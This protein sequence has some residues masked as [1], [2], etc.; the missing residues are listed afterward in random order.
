MTTRDAIQG[1]FKALQ[2][3]NGWESFLADDIAF[4]SFTSPVKRVTGKAAY[5]QATKRFYSTIAAMDLKDLM[6]DGVR[7]CALT[8]YDIKPPNGAP[9]FGSD[10]A[11]VFS[12]KDGK[13]QT[14]DIYFDS[15]PFG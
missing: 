9:G 14:L 1:Y 6:I 11:E 7:A 8:H 3:Q 2:A 5:L 15:A 4:T 13:I 12:V 10:V